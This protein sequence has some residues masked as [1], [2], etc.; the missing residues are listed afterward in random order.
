MA[1]SQTVTVGTSNQEVTIDGDQSYIEIVNIDGA[2]DIYF[3]LD[4]QV[5]VVE[6]D[7]TIVVPAAGG[8][9]VLEIIKH[10]RPETPTKVN[11]IATSSTL[12]QVRGRSH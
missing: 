3:R 2:G 11:L 8:A 6:D 4:G 1:W 9:S 12:V 10:Y 5:A 7:N